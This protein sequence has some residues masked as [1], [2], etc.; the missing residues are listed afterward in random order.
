MVAQ[1]LFAVEKLLEL[2]AR[3]GIHGWFFV[4]AFSL[5]AYKVRWELG[6]NGTAHTFAG[7]QLAFWL[8]AHP[9]FLLAIVN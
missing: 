5:A 2:Q 9:E 1:V 8:H 7:R 3:T 4:L 6:V